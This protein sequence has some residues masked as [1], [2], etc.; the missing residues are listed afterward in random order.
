MLD[1]IVYSLI[2]GGITSIHTPAFKKTGDSTQLKAARKLWAIKFALFS[3]LAAL[4]YYAVVSVLPQL[5][6]VGATVDIVLWLFFLNFLM[7][8]GDAPFYA[9]AVLALLLVVACCSSVTSR[10]EAKAARIGYVERV[11]W[12][13]APPALDLANTP[14]VSNEQAINR[15]AKVLSERYGD[16]YRLGSFTLQKVSGSPF[17][18]APLEFKSFGDWL[19]G[20]YSAGVVVVDALDVNVRARIISVDSKNRPVKLVFTPGA[21]F[22]G[23]LV[24]HI[25]N[26]KGLSLYCKDA[27]LE[28]DDEMK[29]WWV[30]FGYRPGYNGNFKDGGKVLLVDP[31]TGSAQEYTPESTPAWVDVV[32]SRDDLAEKISDSGTF[33]GGLGAALFGFRQ[34]D[35]P[36]TIEGQSVWMV[37][38][39][40]G[41][42]YYYAGL[43]QAIV[44]N[45]RLTSFTLT[46]T[47]SG[48]TIE[49]PCE[50]AMG[51]TPA[52]AVE[53]VTK[54]LS[55]LDGLSAT[56][57]LLCSID[58]KPVYVV[59]I[60]DQTGALKK[61]SL[62]GAQSE[63]IALGEDKESALKEFKRLL[64]SAGAS[65]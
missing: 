15:G 38:G 28:L 48:N 11:S 39:S 58:G 30:V 43:K 32:V 35:S 6:A 53:M 26:T 31:E 47:R 65:S 21:F 37:T 52:A 17:W 27:H 54:K 41:R 55:P 10:A 59:S 36:S 60:V 14:L 61:V 1:T 34:F 13:K 49:Y 51:V 4:F 40:D 63:G 50:G 25:N 33:G 3:F 2:V 16:R 56:S 12:S 8:G 64:K 9:Q 18:V 19:L 7:K 57:P 45:D 5:Y 20:D 62:V 23:Y 42:S 46:D 22:N 24:R 44:R 29:P